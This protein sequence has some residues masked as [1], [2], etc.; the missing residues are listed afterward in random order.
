M[1]VLAAEL[2]AVV[3]SRRD[4]GECGAY[5]G[6]VAAVESDVVEWQG[7]CGLSGVGRRGR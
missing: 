4:F 5:L 7:H 6:V 3:G 2:S 1:G